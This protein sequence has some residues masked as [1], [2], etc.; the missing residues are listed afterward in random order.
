[1][2]VWKEVLLPGRQRDRFGN[3]F[4]V[5][6]R[7]VRRA[8]ANVAKMLSRG[9]PVPT[10]WEHQDVEAGDDAEYRARYAKHTFGSIAGQ[11][12]NGRGALELLHDVPDPND[13]AQLAKTRFVSPKL[14]RGYSDSQGGEYR[15]TTIAHVAATP[16][17]VQYWQRPFELS[18]GQALYLSYTPGGRPMA[19]ENDDDKG[20]KKDDKPKP[21]SAGG[22]STLADVIAALK[23]KG[24]NIPDEVQ[25]EAGLVIAIKAG[26]GLGDDDDDLDAELDAAGAGTPAD[27]G[28]GGGAPMLMSD[29]QAEPFRKMARRDLE[30]RTK[31]LFATGRIDRPTAKKLLGEVKA[32]Q[33]SFTR[34]GEIVSNRTVGK[35]EAYE[36]LPK[37]VVWSKTGQRRADAQE[38]S[39]TRAEPEPGQMLGRGADDKKLLDFMCAGLPAKK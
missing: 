34:D 3:W 1:M 23:E 32:V 24:W 6:P 15:G 19:D 14:Y 8:A 16:T 28:A 38:L 27:T 30:A 26:D 22:K 10:V 37:G 9:V 13:A 18:R 33:L 5:R 25:D 21:G 29:G 20:G 35:I 11:R 12:L 39:D 4:T 31:D 17:P 2:R 7:D 36:A